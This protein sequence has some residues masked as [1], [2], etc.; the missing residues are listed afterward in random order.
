[1]IDKYEEQLLKIIDKLFEL[2]NKKIEPVY[3]YK[4]Y[5]PW[6]HYSYDTA[7]ITPLYPTVTTGCACDEN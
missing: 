4:K 1:M 3:I 2:L 7:D 5:T 6:W